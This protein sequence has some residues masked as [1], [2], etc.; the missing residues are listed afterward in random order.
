MDRSNGNVEQFLND[1]ANLDLIFPKRLTS[2]EV[3]D[4]HDQGRF[5]LNN[6]KLPSNG[7]SHVVN[8]VLWASQYLMEHVDAQKVIREKDKVYRLLEEI[9]S[10]IQQKERVRKSVNETVSNIAKCYIRG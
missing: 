10:L 1:E 8:P 4:L 5:I 3:I 7:T 2:A 6:G 9:Q